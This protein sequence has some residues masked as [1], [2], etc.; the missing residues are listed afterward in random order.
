MNNTLRSRAMKRVSAIFAVGMLTVLPM[1]AASA[2]APLDD[3][4]TPIVDT[5]SAL[6]KVEVEMAIQRVEDAT[7]YRLNVAFVDSFDGMSGARWAVQSAEQ[8]GLVPTQDILF[9]VATEDRAYGSAYPEGTDVARVITKIEDRALSS[10]GAGEWTDAVV[11]YADAVI[12]VHN[13]DLGAVRP[14]PVFNDAPSEPIDFSG[15]FTVLKFIGFALLAAAAGFGAFLLAKIA[16][17]H[18]AIKDEYASLKKQMALSLVELDAMLKKAE[19]EIDYFSAEFPAFNAR[20]AHKANKALETTLAE[21]FEFSSTE[22]VDE[23]TPLRTRVQKGKDVMS[24]HEDIQAAINNMMSDFERQREEARNI[25]EDVPAITKDVDSNAKQIADTLEHIEDLSKRYDASALEEAVRAIES[26]HAYSKSAKEGLSKVAAMSNEAP[27]LLVVAVDSVR[28][29]NERAES[30]LRSAKR[31]IM[32]LSN[33]HRNAQKILGNARMSLR[34]LEESKARTQQAKTQMAA[35]KQALDTYSTHDFKQGSP[36][37]ALADL[38]SVYN[39]LASVERHIRDEERALAEATARF[40]RAKKEIAAMVQEISS[41]YTNK[42]RYLKRASAPSDTKSVAAIQIAEGEV[43][44]GSIIVAVG[45]LEEELRRLNN[46]RSEY[47]NEAARAKREEEEE[48]RRKRRKEEEERRRRNA[49]IYSASTASSFSSY[50]SSSSFGGGGSFGGS[51]G[52]FGG[53]GGSG[54]SF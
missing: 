9:A 39:N 40:P 31:S 10:L 2:V 14:A 30:A 21:T 28:K 44:T 52:S 46:V 35:M 41:F 43:K 12:D 20:K 49:A 29:D 6:D 42:S 33:A 25:L 13:G 27:G 5:V 26:A 32:A 15:F 51:G 4:P 11:K 24:Q 45:I 19:S 50:S 23:K 18:Q 17:A 37:V 38:E 3:L 48:E 47:V 22:F 34:Y 36:L 8:S 7:D 53:S 1:S 16:K 54:G